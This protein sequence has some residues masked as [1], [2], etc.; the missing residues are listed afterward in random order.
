MR[1]RN[2]SYLRPK[3]A[4]CGE[5]IYRID[6]PLGNFPRRKIPSHCPHCGEQISY[7]KKE[8]LIEYEYFLCLIFIII[9]IVC[10]LAISITSN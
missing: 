2:K 10:L 9:I 7:Y 8:H 4:N 3:C 1:Q 6:T 5:Q